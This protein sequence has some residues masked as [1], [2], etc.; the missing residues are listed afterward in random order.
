MRVTRSF[1][2]L[3]TLATLLLGQVAIAGPAKYLVF[4]GV[5]GLKPD[6]YWEADRHGLKIPALR[7]LMERGSY[8]KAVEGV[9]PTVTFP[10][11]STLVTGVN[12]AR[13]G[14]IS[15]I[16]FDPTN[17]NLGGWYWY[18]QDLRVKTLW[19]V[20][21][22]KGLV[23]AALDWPVTAG[24]KI[25][26]NIPEIWR[27]GNAEDAK[28]V[29]LLATPSLVRELEERFGRIPTPYH[30]TDEDRG[31]VAAYVVEH[32][33]PNLALIYFSDLDESQ[34]EHGPYTR[35]VFETLEMID[36]QINRV[37]AAT[38][39]AGIYDQTVFAVA[40]D[41]GFARVEKRINPMAL[42]KVLGF[43]QTDRSGNVKEWKAV[44]DGAALV[45]KDKS[46][47][48]TL[49]RIK[50]IFTILAESPEYGIAR[51]YERAEIDKMGGYPDASLLLEP[52]E[53]FSIGGSPNGDL[54]EKESGGTHGLPAHFPSMKASFLL[55][56]PGIKRGVVLPESR[57]ID[58]APTLAHILGLELSGV[59]GRPLREVLEE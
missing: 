54:L 48:E 38:R 20:A 59:E 24:A 26:F 55:A 32:K 2:L 12:P 30:G 53:G 40:S 43:V 47:T 13:H 29:R 4:F 16:P 37:V 51:I 21:H 46:D 36:R 27:A 18:A 33:R 8:S 1:R 11:N 9:L 39:S 28:L 14:I 45:L 15:N 56:G 42:L 10:S 25:D 35:E 17:Q 50:R 44:M 23:T 58:I 34:H 6:Y 7:A 5:D 31:K 57:M 49:R 19:D 41:H 22:E 3:L 52:A